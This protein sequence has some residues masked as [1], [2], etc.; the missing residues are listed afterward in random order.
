MTIFLNLFSQSEY[1]L[2]LSDS[3][4]EGQECTL[5]KPGRTKSNGFKEKRIILPL[6]LNSE[7]YS[8][9]WDILEDCTSDVKT[10]KENA[11]RRKQR[12]EFPRLVM[13]FIRK[14]VS[15]ENLRNLEKKDNYLYTTARDKDQLAGVGGVTWRG[16]KAFQRTPQ[17]DEI[18]LKG[19]SRHDN[20]PYYE[21]W[22]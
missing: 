18:V 3:Y 1:L 8:F 6:L 13:V 19:L 11:N 20:S 14:M 21:D 16:S 9:S 7:G 22:V 10:L 4:F 12:F 17:K 15:D 5:A 2:D